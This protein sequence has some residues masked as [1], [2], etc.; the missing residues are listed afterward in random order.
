MS[1]CL[2]APAHS[3]RGKKIK[4]FCESIG[5]SVSTFYRHRGDMPKTL[6]IGKQRIIH[7]DDEAEWLARKR[8]EA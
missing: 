1:T 2:S 8:S 3:G 7:P 5:I 4:G 6:R